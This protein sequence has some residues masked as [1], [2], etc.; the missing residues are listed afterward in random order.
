MKRITWP[1]VGDRFKNNAGDW[2]TVIEVNGALD[3]KIKFD[4]EGVE[5]TVSKGNI[6]RGGIRLPKVRV[7]QEVTDKNGASVKIIKIEKGR[8]TFEWSDGY[9]RTCQTSVL[10]TRT[11]MREEDSCKLNPKIKQGSVWKTNDGCLITVIEV[12][13]KN[14]VKIKFHYPVEYEDVVFYGNILQGSI[15]NKFKPSVFGKGYLG[16]YK[17]NVKSK[18]YRTWVS[19]IKRVYAPSNES[20]KIAYEGCF[21]SENWF[22]IGNFA[23]WFYKQKVQDDWELDKDLLFRGNREY[24][25]KTCVF[26]PREI[27]AFLTNRRNHRGPW[28]VGVTYKKT[29]R[30]WEATCSTNNNG[31]G[32]I[33][34]YT[35]PEEAFAAYKE[36]KETFAK[37]LA[38][39]W[40][41]IID[42]R[43]VE[44][45]YSYRVNITD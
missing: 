26:L 35:S 16:K 19:V 28:P 40:K 45:L 8:A 12:L 32:Y 27:N 30:K 41:G 33:G 3:I 39:K 6:I 14:K 15:C 42:D 25:E 13:K 24:S 31:H 11:L 18:M 23:E 38:E 29:I 44:A 36:V 37:N 17:V 43:A 1:V 21:V 2:Y 5:K 10:N 4:T 9:Q 34:V 20:A 7:G 22:Y